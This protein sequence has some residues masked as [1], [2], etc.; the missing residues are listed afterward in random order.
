MGSASNNREKMMVVHSR[1]KLS[2][3]TASRRKTHT[4]THS[5]FLAFFYPCLFGRCCCRVRKLFHCSLHPSSFLLLSF[6]SFRSSSRLFFTHFS[7][8]IER[9]CA[10]SI[11]RCARCTKFNDSTSSYRE[12]QGVVR[13]FFFWL[14]PCLI[15]RL[16]LFMRFIFSSQQ[17]NKTKRWAT[18]CC[19]TTDVTALLQESKLS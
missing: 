6:R 1:F 17:N 5:P 2:P 4:H 9:V 16:P 10:R 19:T 7:L 14:V 13:S 18:K 11:F 8:Y 12:T 15:Y 3:D